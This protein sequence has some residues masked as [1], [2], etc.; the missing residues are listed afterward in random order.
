MQNQETDRF[1]L[2]N[3]FRPAKRAE[4][5]AKASQAGQADHKEEA[6]IGRS[7]CEEMSYIEK[8]I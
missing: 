7:S 4:P 6:S 5:T 8:M 2:I 3:H 1:A